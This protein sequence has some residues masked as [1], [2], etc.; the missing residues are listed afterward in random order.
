MHRKEST[1]IDVGLIMPYN[2]SSTT[3][4]N[5]KDV[6]FGVNKTITGYNKPS[7]I[8]KETISYSYLR[9]N[10][11]LEGK[12]WRNKSLNWSSKNQS[13]KY[14]T[15]DVY[16]EVSNYSYGLLTMKNFYMLC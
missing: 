9:Q 13:Q 11:K 1:T 2:V 6:F 15:K 7:D 16:I 12:I 10:V 5:K 14:F 3:Q 4:I 8:I